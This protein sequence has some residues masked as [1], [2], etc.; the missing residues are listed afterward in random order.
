VCDKI[1]QRKVK[2]RPSRKEL[3][4]MIDNSSL[5]AIGRKCGVSGN[6]IKKWLKN[7]D[8]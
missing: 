4:L 7:M 5:E 2:D 8:Q 6:A 3:I 1:R